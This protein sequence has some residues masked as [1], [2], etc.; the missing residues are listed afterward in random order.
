MSS[1]DAGSGRVH[2]GAGVG[3]HAQVPRGQKQNLLV[4]AD[5]CRLTG[6]LWLAG[7]TDD[8]EGRAG[9]IPAGEVVEVGILAIRI[10]VQHRL[11]GS[12]EDGDSAM[13]IIAKRDTTSVVV[14]RR[15]LLE[16]R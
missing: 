12:E 16:C 6:T 11:F 2:L 15:L 10:E 14:A 4:L 7:G 5:A 13:K 8:Q 9:F 1:G 3:F